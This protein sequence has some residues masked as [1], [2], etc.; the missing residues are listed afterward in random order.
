MDRLTMAKIDQYFDFL[1]KNNGSDLHL[2]A[3][4]PVKVRI[5]G[6]LEPISKKALTNAEA[7]ALLLE[8]LDE[9][10]AK[11]FAEE[12]DLDFA[13]ELGDRARFRSNF[14]RQVHG[15]GAVFRLIP[16]AIKPL[17]SLGVPLVIEQFAKLK[18]GLVLVT[19]PT[20]SGKSTTLAALVDYI[21]GNYK[22]HII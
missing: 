5:H 22:K 9:R 16:S 8:I 11:R 2:S 4:L 21:N 13:Y 19:G 14:F 7:E 3:G 15:I 18:S 1:I 12:L 20:G 10:Q 17:A 6:N